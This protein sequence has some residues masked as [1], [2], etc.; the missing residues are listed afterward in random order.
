[1]TR[2]F[3]LT[4]PTAFLALTLPACA[5]ITLPG[6]EPV[7]SGRLWK[8]WS[9]YERLVYLR[10]F[11]DGSFYAI[12]HSAPP[13][14]IKEIALRYGFTQIRDVITSLYSDPANAYINLSAMVFIARDKLDGQ[15]AE[16]LLTKARQDNCDYD[17][18]P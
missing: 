15:N 10:G 11:H 1:M 3:A 4:I 7:D 17:K 8:S 9:A 14:A 16:Q 6:F 5:C 18:S 13:Q 12:E 2:F